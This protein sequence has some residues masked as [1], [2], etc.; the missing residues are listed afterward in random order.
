[1][2]FFLVSSHYGWQSDARPPALTLEV[3]QNWGSD[4]CF[5][6][7]GWRDLN[8]WSGFHCCHSYLFVFI[9]YEPCGYYLL[10]MEE[11][12]KVSACDF[13]HLGTS[14]HIVTSKH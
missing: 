1:M 10:K 11:L 9:C 3:V 6:V 8:H 4:D 7:L 5:P 12:N 13:I 2:L 14:L